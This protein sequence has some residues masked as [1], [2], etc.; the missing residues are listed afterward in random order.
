MLVFE[1]KACVELTPAQSLFLS[2]DVGLDRFREATEADTETFPCVSFGR[3][4]EFLVQETDLLVEHDASHWDT[5]PP[6]VW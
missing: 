2:K 5:C 4:V 6:W 1:D 3:L